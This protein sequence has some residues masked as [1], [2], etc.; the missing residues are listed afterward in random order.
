M[1]CLTMIVKNESAVI[2]R[3]LESVR[4]FIDRWCIVDTGST[5]DTEV[6][7]CNALNGIPGAYHHAKWK[8]FGHA[9]S[10]AF[11]WAGREGYALVVDADETVSGDPAALR[12]A[13]TAN[14]CGVW[15]EMGATRFRQLRVFDL[16]SRE[17]RYE[18]VLHEY[19]TCDG[20]FGEVD[21]P[22][23]ALRITPRGDSARAVDP[24]KWK[25]DV[26]VLDEALAKRPPAQLA[27]RYTFYLAQSL[28]CAGDYARAA[29][30][31]LKRADMGA[32]S[33]IEEIY[34]ALLE[35]GRALVLAGGNP[36]EP[37]L[38][39][40]EARPLR[41]E[42][43]HELAKYFRLRHAYQNAYLFASAAARLG[44]P[45]D[46]LFVEDDVYT[47][48]ALDELALACFYTGRKDEAARITAQLL[49]PMPEFER[50]RIQENL[51]QV[52]M[53]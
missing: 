38:R 5:D 48:R 29:K 31:Y 10:L 18:G 41:A 2:A 50:A 51:R 9:R 27:A 11:G 13:L 46:T 15:L 36:V 7:V 16:E 44:R 17:W 49:S 28:R 24:K 1:I 45:N 25:R 40:H 33:N 53:A 20:G 4:P 12:A 52:R 39:A 30:I 8:G 19:P 6:V 32:G 47:W 43:L 34:V 22:S 23:T 35:A 21:I 37:W 3:T 42:V 14:A 26:K